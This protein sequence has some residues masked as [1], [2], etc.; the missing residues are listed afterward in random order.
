MDWDGR[1]YACKVI[2]RNRHST[3]ASDIIVERKTAQTISKGRHP[4]VVEV[5]DTWIEE[6]S[7]ITTCFIQ[8]ELCQGDL[9]EFLQARYHNLS[10][11][12]L[13]S[14]IWGTFGQI[15]SG[16]EYIHSQGIIHR[17]LKPKNGTASNVYY[18]FVT[19]SYTTVYERHRRKSDMENHRFW[20][21]GTFI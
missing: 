3:T 18:M 20:L 5:L 17:D 13:S 4:N 16:L 7:F 9:A 1:S 15:M 2:R 12:L 11:G 8:M 21:F 10:K 19:D 14:E 6:T